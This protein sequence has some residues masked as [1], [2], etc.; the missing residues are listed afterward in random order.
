MGDLSQFV[1]DDLRPDNEDESHRCER[2]I[3]APSDHR[4]TRSGFIISVVGR[5]GFSCSAAS[6]GDDH[7]TRDAPAAVAGWVGDEVVL[8]GVDHDCAPVRIEH[9]QR[10]VRQR[11]CLG[12][13]VEA[14]LPGVV[15][16]Q[17]REVPGVGPMRCAERVVMG[18]SGR[19]RRGAQTGVVDVNAVSA[20]GEAEADFSIA[21]N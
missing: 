10:P 6:S 3:A 18:A 19:E 20:L 17:V 9:R 21:A 4:S 12:G 7:A 11:R 1:I 5:L 13:R 14:A 8:G 16:D 15:D 2:S